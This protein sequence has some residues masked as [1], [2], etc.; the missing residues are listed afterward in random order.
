MRCLAWAKCT[1]ARTSWLQGVGCNGSGCVV[2]GRARIYF[3]ASGV[4]AA[5]RLCWLCGLGGSFGG[6]FSGIGWGSVRA[7]AG[8]GGW[9]GF[10]RFRSTAF[11]GL[12]PGGKNWNT[13]EHQ[14]NE[15]PFCKLNSSR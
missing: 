4:M 11:Y 15:F 1:G 13:K 14:R 12:S 9:E 8:L 6:V 7:G 2:P 10:A 3:A 5:T